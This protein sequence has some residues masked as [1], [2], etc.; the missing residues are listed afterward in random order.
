MDEDWRNAFGNL[1][2]MEIYDGAGAGICD[3]SP[4]TCFSIYPI[5]TLS[6]LGIIFNREHIEIFFLFSQTTGFDISCKLFPLETI[7]MKCQILF[8]GKIGISCKLSPVETICM[9]C[10]IRFSGK[11]KKNITNLS[12]AKLA[13]RVARLKH[14]DK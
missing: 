6:T 7:C 13:K 12:S 1:M 4:S 9:K 14:Q 2:C 10:Q 5:L 3:G 11:S 8:S